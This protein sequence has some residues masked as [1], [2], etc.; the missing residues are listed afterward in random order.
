MPKAR[1]GSFSITDHRVEAGLSIHEM[2]WTP[3]QIASRGNGKPAKKSRARGVAPVEERTYKGKVYHSK[4]EARYAQVLDFA[5]KAGTVISFK[6]QVRIPLIVK[7]V[8][9]CKMVADFEVILPCG[10]RELVEVKGHKTDI[11]NLKWKLFK[12]LHPNILY[13][14]V[15]ARSIK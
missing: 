1:R 6:E 13:T 5:I 4:A 9:V 11:Y 2:N 7:G 8:I 3:E 14:I 12:A 10:A 15:D